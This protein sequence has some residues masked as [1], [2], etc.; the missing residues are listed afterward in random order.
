[1][2][3]QLK[4]I[5]ILN[6]VCCIFVVL[7][8]LTSE[9]VSI[10][11]KGSLDYK[12]FYSINKGISFVVPAFIFLSGFKLTNSYKNKEFKFV[13]FIKKRFSKIFIPY[14]CWFVFYYIYLYN[15]QYIE[16]TDL[17]GIVKLFIMGDLIAPFYFITLIFQFYLIFGLLKFLHE[18]YRMYFLLIST[19]LNLVA[20]SY[21]FKY[22]DRFFINYLI[23][24]IMG[25]ELAINKSKIDKFLQN[26][27]VIVILLSITY[28]VI[29]LSLGYY[30]L[31]N[32]YLD[33]AFKIVSI[34]FYY[35]IAILLSKINFKFYN[36]SVFYLDKA[37]FYVFLS[38]CFFLYH[39]NRVWHEMNIYMPNRFYLN[40]VLVYFCSFFISI[41]YV[42]I[43]R[44]FKR[45]NIKIAKV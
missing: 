33:F 5:S 38:H 22:S 37:S 23:Y 43:K 28:I 15:I 26:K 42:I 2:T 21:F 8:H 34:V 32:V 1:M 13:D 20:I 19:I 27:K 39:F 12:I 24:F 30:S 16:P 17:F 44:K 36:I 40:L 18:K 45:R 3:K 9:N 35:T 7:I 25:M 10:L 11:Y 31:L 29:Y 41:F 14:L 6:I 4:E